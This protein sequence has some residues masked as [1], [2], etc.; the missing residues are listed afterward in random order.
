M[1]FPKKL[2]LFGFFIAFSLSYTGPIIEGD[3]FYHLSTGKTILEDKGIPSGFPTQWFGQVILYL[4]WRLSGFEGIV[5]MRAGIYTGILIFL[6]AWM[7]K[8]DVP[9]L[10]CLFFLLFPA[11]IFLSFPNE[12]PQI[13]S[14]LL[15]PLN[16]YLLE[17]MRQQRKIGFYGLLF[18]LPL[19]ANI[20]TGFLIGLACIWIYFIGGLISYLRKKTDLKSLIPITIIA[21]TP[22]FALFFMPSA[23]SYISDIVQSFL[24][25]NPYMKSIQEYLSPFSAA[26]NLNEYYPS[27]WLFLLIALYTLLRNLRRMPFEHIFLFSLLIFLSFTGLRFI[28]FFMMLTPLIAYRLIHRKEDTSWEDSKLLFAGFFLILILWVTLITPRFRLGISREFPQDSVR[29]LKETKPYG[30]GFNYYGWSGYLKW[31]AP[32]M[33][34]FIQVGNISSDTDS[35]YGD[36]IWANNTITFNKPQWRAILDAYSLDII[37]MP[38]ISPVSG[39]MY[40]LMDALQNDKDWYLIYSDDVSNIFIRS[41]KENERLINIYSMP[42]T[43]IYLQ[44]VAQAK[45]YLKEKPKNKVLWR[46]LGDSYMRL[47]DIKKAKEAYKHVK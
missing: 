13:I 2:L 4:V 22:A 35:A 32:E 42:K 34:I 39:Q 37:M 8:M 21:I 20:H 40:P 43:N 27:Y 33:P 7:R 28:P 16:I 25:P 1:S 17:L 11:H 10:G 24:M 30:K 47:G 5:L 44:V 23:L 36:I 15:F 26:L 45:R 14:F 29:F 41:K 18:L 31:S 46:T 6:F 19:W 9:F 12:R 38:G 3:F